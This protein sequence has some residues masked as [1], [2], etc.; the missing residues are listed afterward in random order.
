M[1]DDIIA[2]RM[3]ALAWALTF[4]DGA[5]GALEVGQELSRRGWRAHFFLVT[6]LIDRVGFLRS[7]EVRAL[8]ALGH[9]VGS[10][11]C[12]HPERMS[13]LSRGQMASEWGRSCGRLSELLG[14]PTTTASVP[15]GYYSRRVAQAAAAAGVTGLFTSEP[16]RGLWSVD[17]CT[18]VG[19]YA[20]HR[21][22]EVAEVADVAA[23][24]PLPWMR[25]NLFWTAR[26]LAKAV[27]GERYKTVRI[28]LLSRR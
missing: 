2:G 25:T 4:D 22:T 5:A 14:K 13:H 3:S 9:I 20:V 23:G 11:S 17:R 10:H 6:D 12:S 15:G 21:G 1:I 28:A 24:M 7:D 26:K 19:R 8:D 18:V 27:A 16:V